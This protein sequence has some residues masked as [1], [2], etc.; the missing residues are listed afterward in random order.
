MSTNWNEQEA[1]QEC[2]DRYEW[3]NIQARKQNKRIY[4]R[5][6]YSFWEYEHELVNKPSNLEIVNEQDKIEVQLEHLRETREYFIKCYVKYVAHCK[7]WN[8]KIYLDSFSPEQSKL[9]L[10]TIAV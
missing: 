6:Q 4:R 5:M 7:L 2:A 8:I 10:N 1:A 3:Y 9:I